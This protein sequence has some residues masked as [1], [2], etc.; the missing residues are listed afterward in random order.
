MS[1]MVA[2][3]NA[4]PTW[5]SECISQTRKIGVFDW[6]TDFKFQSK[7]WERHSVLPGTG[8]AERG[9]LMKYASCPGAGKRGGGGTIQ[10]RVDSCWRAGSMPITL[11][12]TIAVESGRTIMLH[13]RD[14]ETCSHSD[15]GVS[16]PSQLR[17]KQENS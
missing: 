16:L 14:G 17:S 1:V 9:H 15:P 2:A 11:G 8:A 12:N 3:A 5:L 4:P 7:F 13:H 10:T 6:T